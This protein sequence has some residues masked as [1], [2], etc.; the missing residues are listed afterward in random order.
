MK[1]VLCAALGLFLFSGVAFTQ[2]K[3]MGPG[4]GGSTYIPTISSHS[5]D[6]LTVSCDM[7]AYYITE[8]GGKNWEM[9]NLHS[10]VYLSVFDPIEPKVVYAGSDALYRSDDLGKTWKTV[11]SKEKLA[12]A[13]P[14]M[15]AIDP[16]NNNVL[17]LAVG[18]RE[19]IEDENVF[20]ELLISTDKGIKWT[21]IGDGLPVGSSIG[22]IYIDR[23]SDA[24]KR[25]VYIGT[26]KGVYVSAD[27]GMSFAQSPIGLPGENVTMLS[28]GTNSE[29]T[30]VYVVIPDKGVYKTED[31]G[32]SWTKTDAPE[33][34]YSRLTVANNNPDIAYLSTDEDI[35]KTVDGGA[36]WEG[37][38]YDYNSTDG[39]IKYSFSSG[40]GW[41][42]GPIKGLYVSAA[43]SNA[44]GFTTS[45]GTFLTVDGGTNWNAVYSISKGKNKWSGSGLEE[46]TSYS[47]HFDPKNSKTMYLTYTDIG[48]WKSID[49]GESW[50]FL[51]K[52]APVAGSG[53]IFWIE[54]DPD[55]T[56]MLYAVASSMHDIP[57]E[58][59][60]KRDLANVKGGLIISKDGGKSWSRA[61]GG[62][63]EA[64]FTSVFLDPSSPPKARTLFVTMLGKGV[65]KSVDGGKKWTEANTGLTGSKNAWRIIKSG[66][67]LYL[68]VLP[69]IQ[70]RPGTPG[71]VYVSADNG[72]KWEKVNKSLEIAY[73]TD[74]AVHPLNPDIIY[75]SAYYGYAVLYDGKEYLGGVYR[76]V[77]GGKN[78]K[79]MVDKNY[80][81]G[82]TVDNRM[83]DLVYAGYC[84]DNDVPSASGYFVSKNKGETWENIT[85]VPFRNTHRV[86]IDPKDINKLYIT[87]FGGGVIVNK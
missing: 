49:G 11:L 55:N 48:L 73:P 33:A 13:M 74:V 45:G 41:H 66:K 80:F 43:D 83:P 67:K 20:G 58:W 84:E 22:G 60:L 70:K 9:I 38:M 6:I 4:G 36:S 62:L 31:N 3:T 21:K 37:V 35:M 7:G 32:N 68:V 2:W 5:N 77:D 75:I 27:N 14:L 81:Y 30:S 72:A 79:R 54:I 71:A 86:I 29:K 10:H 44:V 25:I 50:E 85:D 53:N 28:G 18:K 12:D 57:E 47:V 51:V 15:L 64:G 40:W 65:Y 76:S 8:N 17:F 16:E 56:N 69:N 26:T 24:S 39:W 59:T 82:L 1:K 23:N 63:P 46:T 34:G 52:N 19:V 61:D 87:T 42:F 78:W